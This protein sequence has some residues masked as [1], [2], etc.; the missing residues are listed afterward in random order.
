MAEEP[1]R[2]TQA[3]TAERIRRRAE[4]ERNERI[5]RLIPFGIIGAV[6]VLLVGFAVTSTLRASGVFS[7]PN[8]KPNFTVDTEKLELGD[9][10]LGSTV[11]ATFNVKNTGQ[12]A[13]QLNVPPMPSVLEGC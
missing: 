3:R 13:L 6:L 10:K 12:G 7:D 11:R 5:K 8:A 2:K 1:V 9:Q 4:R